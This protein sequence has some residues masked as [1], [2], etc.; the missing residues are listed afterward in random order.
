MMNLYTTKNNR[1]EIIDKPEDGCWVSMVRP[2]EEE[3]TLISEACAVDKDAL[4]AALDP[5]ERSRIESDDLYTMIL[6]NIPTVEEQNDRELYNTIPLSIIVT[7]TTVI[8]VCSE[9]SAVLQQFANG[10]IRDFHT[11]MKSR[12]ILQILYK[13]AMLYLLYLHNIDK[14]SEEVEN[15]LHKSTENRELIELLKLEKSL[16]YFTTSL[17]SNEVVLEKLLRNEIIKKYPEDADLLEDVIVENKQAIEMANIYSGI[18]SGM[19]D[20][21][22]SVISNNLNIVM[23]VLAII[24]VV[25]AIPTIIFS[26]YGMNVAMTGMP[27]ANSPYGFWIIV[28]ISVVLSV[29]VTLIFGKLKMFK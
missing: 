7:E 15:K 23:K 14:K 10:K 17:R 18:L 25:M 19:M 20:A 2:K 6:V 16:V 22:A 21:F 24:T 12:F 8:T 3:I 27:F 4:R 29:L 26:A 9:D 1:L 28:V 5:D 11:N 13:I